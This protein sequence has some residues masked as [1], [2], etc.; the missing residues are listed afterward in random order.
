MGTMK[1]E[2]R[3]GRAAFVPGEAIAGTA[4]WSFD[5]Q[6]DAVEL[7]L[8]WYTQGKGTQDVGVVETVPYGPVAREDRRE[9][10]LHLPASPYS[11][12]G[13]LI[14]LLWALELVAQ[15]SGESARFEFVLGP[16]GKEVVLPEP[17]PPKEDP[18]GPPRGFFIKIFRGPAPHPRE[19]MDDG[20]KT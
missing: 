8:I 9:F 10:K 20:R 13:K 16:G 6:P 14:S 1:V 15:P 4:S 12:S 19:F 7:R 17:P 2:S 18:A 3:D 5:A 11:F